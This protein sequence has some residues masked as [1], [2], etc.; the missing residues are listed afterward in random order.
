M[1]TASPYIPV[2]RIKEQ[3]R[4]QTRELKKLDSEKEKTDAKIKYI[5]EVSQKKI[6][7]LKTELAEKEQHLQN[8]TLAAQAQRRHSKNPDQAQEALKDSP[9]SEEILENLDVK[10]SEPVPVK[11]VFVRDPKL[12]QALQILKEKNEA[13][14]ERIQAEREEREKLKKE[15]A[16]LLNEV[17]RLRNNPEKIREVKKEVEEVEIQSKEAQERYE[18]LLNENHRLMS[19]Y[20]KLIT[21]QSQVDNKNQHHLE[22]I[23]ELKRELES[24]RAERDVLEFDLREEKDMF[25]HHLAQEIEKI[26]KDLHDKIKSLRKNNSMVTQF[27]DQVMDEPEAPL[28]M[29][30]Y[31]DMVTLLL[32]FFI[33]YYSIASVNLEKFKEAILGEESASIGLLELLDSIDVK[34]SIQSLTGLKSGD[35]LADIKNVVK[36]QSSLEVAV[37]DAKVVVQVPGGTLFLP[38][39]ADLQKA[40]LPVLNEVIRVLQKYPDYQ[41]NIRG[42]TDD[43]PISSERFPT[44]WELS[45]ARATAVLRHFIDRSIDP[46]DLTATGFADTFPLVSNA[47]EAGRE[48]NRR[49]EIVLEKQ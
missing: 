4:A 20:E 6:L 2:E 41:V 40:G 5:L 36:E 16:L 27:A 33:L 38:G 21:D 17:K 42:H 47:T 48:K 35:I 14:K 26:E 44:N 3:L 31:A 23:Q 24:L 10:F 49:V 29:I 32:T 9:S 13:L 7:T 45:A 28:W 19:S 30:T 43:T 34:E 11:E 18:Q 15:R 22:T 25:N 37:R 46:E 1:K 12:V 39:S 8:R